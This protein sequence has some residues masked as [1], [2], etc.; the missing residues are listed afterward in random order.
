MHHGQALPRAFC[1]RFVLSSELPGEEAAAHGRNSSALGW[2]GGGTHFLNRLCLW[3]CGCGWP[4]AQRHFFFFALSPCIGKQMVQYVKKQLRA[5]LQ[6]WQRS[7]HQDLPHRRP[8]AR[9]LPAHLC[10]SALSE[11]IRFVDMGGTWADV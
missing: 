6:G 3:M 1:T 4:F 10:A 5:K 7:E 11:D 8:G 9:F 2:G